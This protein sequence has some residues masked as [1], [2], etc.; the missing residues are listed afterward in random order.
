MKTNKKNGEKPL[1]FEEVIDEAIQR[2]DWFS[3]FS[4]A[5]TYF[6]H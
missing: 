3:A 1:S 2:E 4:N 6:E 5:V